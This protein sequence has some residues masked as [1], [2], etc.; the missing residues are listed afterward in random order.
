MCVYVCACVRMHMCA[1][2][3]IHLILMLPFP[4]EMKLD[5]NVICKTVWN[6]NEANNGI[7]NNTHTCTYEKKKL[8]FTLMPRR[9]KNVIE[10]DSMCLPNVGMSKIESRW[11]M[12][13]Q[14]SMKR[15]SDFSIDLY[16]YAFES[17]SVRIQLFS[18]IIC[19]LLE[20][21][22]DNPIIYHTIMQW[23]LYR[24]FCANESYR[25]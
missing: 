11:R 10:W 22:H 13:T 6:G 7:T 4:N 21:Y 3:T 16:I 14:Q 18:P 12:V 8:S 2:Q 23:Q 1:R 5:G 24:S 20:I 9:K 15:E 17:Y 25:M 19:L